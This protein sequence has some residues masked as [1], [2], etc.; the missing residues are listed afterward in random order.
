MFTTLHYRSVHLLISR[1]SIKKLFLVCPTDGMEQPILN[2]FKGDAFFYT[3]LG[4]N[5]DFEF[6][7]QSEIWN[8]IC[9]QRIE[10]LVFVTAMN[11]VFY[12]HALD[13]NTNLD[14]IVNEQ[15][16]KPNYM[17]KDLNHSEVFFSNNYL[18]VAQHLKNQKQRLLSTSFL[19]N[20]LQE[21]K[22]LVDAYVYQHEKMIFTNY[23]EIEKTGHFLNNISSN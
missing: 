17:Y 21:E 16:V 11:N 22:I 23:L 4:A 13:K 6:I 19:G 8:L 18:I 10:M 2:H 1:I 20:R 3:S 15:L 7:E 5:F 14:F 9:E 12:N